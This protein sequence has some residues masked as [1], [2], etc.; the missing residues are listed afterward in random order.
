MSPIKGGN[1][2][3]EEWFARI[4]SQGALRGVCISRPL[5][6]QSSP[7]SSLPFLPPWTRPRVQWFI[8]GH[9][10]LHLRPAT[11][12]GR[13]LEQIVWHL[14]LNCK[15]EVTIILIVGQKK[16]SELKWKFLGSCNKQRKEWEPQS[17]DLKSV[18]M[19]PISSVFLL[20]FHQ[21]GFLQEATY[22]IAGR[23]RT[24]SDETGFFAC[25]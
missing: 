22:W 21:T 12:Q 18:G 25:F 24:S 20:Q 23:S 7:F 5:A 6:F 13:S 9:L 11:Y 15:V 10:Y 17:Q 16:T 3:D 19:F 8:C 2:A 4:H 1:A 14:Q